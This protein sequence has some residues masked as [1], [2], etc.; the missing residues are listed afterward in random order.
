VIANERAARRELGEFLDREGI[1]YVDALPALRA[2]AGQQL[3]YRGP[4]DMH[5]AANGY[6]VIAGVAEQLLRD[7][8]AAGSRAGMQ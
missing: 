6:R 5:P 1:T 3:Y 8:R 2:A 7:A 4:A